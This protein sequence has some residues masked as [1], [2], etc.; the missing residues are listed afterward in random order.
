MIIK[1][2]FLCQKTKNN[3][4]NTKKRPINITETCVLFDYLIIIRIW[5]VDWVRDVLTLKQKNLEVA[6]E[7]KAEVVYDLGFSF[8]PLYK[9]N[10]DTPDTLT[11]LK[12]QPGISPLDLP[13]LPKPE[14]KTSSCNENEFDE[15][16]EKSNDIANN[17]RFHRHSLSNHL[18]GRNRQL[19]FRS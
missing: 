14:I 1:I 8:F 16:S 12:R 10:K 13:R 19:S 2:V 7:G 6:C 18:L 15:Q 5:K 4:D 11:T 9:A 3:F 17:S